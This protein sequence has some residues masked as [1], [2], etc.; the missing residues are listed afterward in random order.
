MINAGIS[1]PK[2][3][4]KINKI[5]KATELGINA[6]NDFDTAGG[7]PSGKRITQLCSVNNCRT[8]TQ[9]IATNNAVKIPFYPK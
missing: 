7:T 3:Q 8:L 9:K 1:I 2:T 4:R 6:E 5:A